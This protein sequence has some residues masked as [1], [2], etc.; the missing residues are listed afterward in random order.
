KGRLYPG[1]QPHGAQ[2]TTMMNDVAYRALMSGAEVFPAGSIIVKQNFMPDGM[3]AR[4]TTMY[5]SAGYNPDVNDWFFAKY[6]PTG[7]L[8]AMPNGMPMEGRLPGCQG[9]HLAKQ[10]ND[11][12]FTA[13][14]GS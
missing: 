6:L 2:L 4:V 11:Y 10:D 1:Q 9:C 13:E 7:E 12:I 3:L 8:D 5:K 14:L